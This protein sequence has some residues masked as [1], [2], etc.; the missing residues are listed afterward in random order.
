MD[1]IDLK[2]R[3]CLLMVLVEWIKYWL[4]G[5]LGGK[6]EGPFSV[7]IEVYLQMATPSWC[8]IPDSCL[9]SPVKNLIDIFKQRCDENTLS[10]GDIYKHCIDEDGNLNWEILQSVFPIDITSETA[11][12]YVNA[13]SN[14]SPAILRISCAMMQLEEISEDIIGRLQWTDNI[15]VL[16][17]CFEQ[18]KSGDSVFLIKHRVVPFLLKDLLSSDNLK[19]A[20]GKCPMQVLQVLIGPP[21]SLNLRNLVWHGFIAQNELPLSFSWFLFGIIAGIGNLLKMKIIPRRLTLNLSQISELIGKFPILTVEEVRKFDE[22][23]HCYH[24]IPKSAVLYTTFDEILAHSIDGQENK[25]RTV[26]GDNFLVSFP[27]N[28]TR[29]NYRRERMRGFV[30]FE[31]LV[32]SHWSAHLLF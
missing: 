4:V 26:V 30:E 15:P 7:F 12:W 21:V 11:D 19:N 3:M 5:W 1:R 22:S 16:K 28:L 32:E 2:Y 20:I 8:V 24:I 31:F 13:I 18:M 25:I 17:N 23:T 9:S 27:E 29:E 10:D 14:L 6:R